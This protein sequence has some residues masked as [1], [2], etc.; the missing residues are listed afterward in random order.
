MTVGSEPIV[1]HHAGDG[2]HLGAKA[3]DEE[4]VYHIFGADMQENRAPHGQME[5][6]V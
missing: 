6:A 1:R 3:G 2:V 5:L 4:A